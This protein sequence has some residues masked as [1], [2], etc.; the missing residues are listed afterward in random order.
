MKCFK[1]KYKHNF[2]FHIASFAFKLQSAL[3]KSN[4]IK[5]NSSFLMGHD[6]DFILP[7]KKKTIIL[8]VLLERIKL[9][10]WENFV[11]KVQW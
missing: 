8:Q 7:R 10:H 5:L 3:S 2:L 9:L 11:F 6:G 1:T 4:Q